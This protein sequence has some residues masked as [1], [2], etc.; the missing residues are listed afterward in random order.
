[1]SEPR[2]VDHEVEVVLCVTTTRDDVR[3]ALDRSGIA[4]GLLIGEALIEAVEVT[5][6]D[7][8]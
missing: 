2:F 5:E 6:R 4:P 7:E 3:A 1:M 8:E